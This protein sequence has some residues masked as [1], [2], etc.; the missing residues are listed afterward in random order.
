MKILIIFLLFSLGVFSQPLQVSSPLRFLALGDSYTVGENLSANQ[1]WPAQLMDSLAA[2]NVV[3]DTM[4]IIARTGWRTD[5]LINAI[6]NQQLEKQSYNLVSV[7]IGANHVY[8]NTPLGKYMIEFPQLLDSAIRFAGG[9]TSR[10]FI[11]SIPDF[12]ATPLGQRTCTEAISQNIN[13]YNRINKN[14]ANQ[15]HIRYF[16]V[17]PISRFGIYKPYL[18]ADDELHPSAYQ[19]AAWVKLLLTDDLKAVL[20]DFED[21]EM[22]VYPNS[23]IDRITISYPLRINK[24]VEV[25]N[26]IGNLMLTQEMNTET[27]VLQLIDLNQ[28]IYTIRL[29][30]KGGQI[31]KKIIK[32]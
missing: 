9:D 19:Y 17:T 1:S 7:L 4:R 28:G 14:F 31:S 32:Q 23:V 3:I 12:A 20:Q 11:V 8:Q 24:T 15:Y 10:V 29:I 27:T 25:Y 18:V 13:Q 5:N 21:K 2:R 16:D 6:T 22:L 30:Y 26:S